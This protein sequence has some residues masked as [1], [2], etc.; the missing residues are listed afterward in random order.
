M[1]K[2]ELEIAEQH[3]CGCVE[4]DNVINTWQ[5]YCRQKATLSKKYNSH[6]KTVE[7][8]D[9]FA[10]LIKSQKEF[11]HNATTVFFVSDTSEG[12]NETKTS[13]QWRLDQMFEAFCEWA[14]VFTL[15]LSR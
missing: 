15:R 4:F 10:R 8:E 1:I 3:R 2:S 13:M 5:T 9:L 11:F 12:S 6:H 7:I 14:F